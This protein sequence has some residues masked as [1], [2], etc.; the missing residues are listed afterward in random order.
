[1]RF[2]LDT[3]FIE[4][5][6]KIDLVSIGIVSEDGREY[7]AVSSD[8]DRSRAN[9]WVKKNVLPQVDWSLA[10]PRSQ[11]RTELIEFCGF[12][13]YDHDSG[14]KHQHEFWANYGAY[15]WVVLCQLFGSMDDLPEGWPM[16]CHDLQQLC[17]ATGNPDLPKQEGGHQAVEDARWLR[18]AWSCCTRQ[19]PNSVARKV[20]DPYAEV[21]IT[22][23]EVTPDIPEQRLLINP[24]T[25]QAFSM[26]RDGQKRLIAR[27]RIL[28]SLKMGDTFL[29]RTP[30]LNYTT[31]I[32][33]CSSMYLRAIRVS[34]GDGLTEEYMKR[35]WDAQF[36]FLV[37]G[38][39]LIQKKLRSLL[40]VKEVVLSERSKKVGC[41]FQ[42]HSAGA[43]GSIWTGYMLPNGS[44]I[45]AE[46]DKIPPGGGEVVVKISC[47]LGIYT[48]EGLK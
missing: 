13:T 15:D 22:D 16:Y 5:G 11:I 30:I 39:P 2:W 26:R 8:C 37:D 1:M 6:R 29:M 23:I 47:D 21:S 42:A 18:D 12:A 10:R 14:T 40:G 20:L 43:E 25:D 19:D 45:Q 35:L 41:L 38:E 24:I 31:E 17:E 48:A 3:E 33:V 44:R 27:K 7:Y 36:E 4:D 34:I 32:R 28:T 9:P 46:L